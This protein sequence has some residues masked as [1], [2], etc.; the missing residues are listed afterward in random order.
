MVSRLRPR[1]PSIHGHYRQENRRTASGQ[2]GSG[3]WWFSSHG[4]PAPGDHKRLLT[5]LLKDYEAK[6][7]IDTCDRYVRG[8][9]PMIRKIIKACRWRT[10]LSIK[11][12]DMN[13]Y[14]VKLREEY[15]ARTVASHIVSIKCFTRWLVRCGK[16]SADPLAGVRRPSPRREMRRRMLLPAEWR[17]LRRTTLTEGKE[18]HSATSQRGRSF[19][20][21]LSRLDIDTT[22]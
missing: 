7:S 1:R 13:R 11:E 2:T 14:A 8:T 6:L 18:R 15:T 19:T 9:V 20:A 16:L 12:A 4:L 3:I 17:E 10:A 21:R 22:N 5:D